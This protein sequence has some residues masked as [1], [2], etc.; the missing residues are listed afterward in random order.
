MD[1][2][3]YALKQLS[4]EIDWFNMEKATLTKKLKEQ[5]DLILD[6]EIRLVKT[7]NVNLDWASK[8][9]DGN[10]LEKRVLDFALREKYKNFT[11]A[12]KDYCLRGER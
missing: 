7:V 8:D 4:F 10:D 3:S 1:K 12:F 6:L 11:D 9:K 2:L 5:E